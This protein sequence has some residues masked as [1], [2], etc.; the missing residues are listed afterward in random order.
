MERIVNY[1]LSYATKEGKEPSTDKELS[2]VLAL[3][4]MAAKTEAEGKGY[5]NIGD[6]TDLLVVERFLEDE[7]MNTVDV[8]AIQRD[9]DNIRKL[10]PLIC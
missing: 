10:F 9:A 5:G 6:P 1:F 2:E 4:S 3:A 8:E 7:F